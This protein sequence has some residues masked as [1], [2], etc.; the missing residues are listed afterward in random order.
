MMG[1]K[2]FHCDL[3]VYHSDKFSI[4]INGSKRLMCCPGCLAVAKFILES[5]FSDYYLYRDKPGSTIDEKFLK[6][7]FTLDLYNDNTMQKR[8]VQKDDGKTWSVT[9]AIDGITCAACTWLIERHL[10]AVKG[11]YKISVNLATCRAIITYNLEIISLSYILNEFRSIGYLA[12]PYTPKQQEVLF[13]NE[14]RRELKKLIVSAIGMLQVM[15]L[16]AALYIG[17]LRDM[18]QNYWIFI[19]WICF[20][21]TC[22]VLF[23]SARGIFYNALR[24]I[25]LKNFGMDTTVSLSLFIAFI[26]SMWN[27]I[28]KTGDIYFDSICMF[29]FFLLIGRFLEMRARHHS[30]E[31]IYGLQEL[32]V[33][34]AIIV[35]KENN[36]YNE[37]IVAIENVQVGDNILV[38]PGESIPIDGEIVEGNSSISESMITG[39]SMPI[40]KIVGDYVI[41]GTVNI[42]NDL[43][44]KAVKIKGTSTIDVMIQLLEKVSSVKPE[45][46]VLVN[47][48]AGYFVLIVIFLTMV[49]SLVWFKLGHNNVLN[50]ILSMLVVACPC[51]LSLATPVA[52]T[53]SVNALARKGFLIT[54]E[55]VLENL[56]LVTDIVFDK[57]GTLTVNNFFINKIRLNKNVTVKDVFSIAMSL[58]ENS[59]HPIARAFMSS[60]IPSYKII[61]SKNNIKNYI[62]EGVEGKLDGVVYRLGKPDFIKEWTKNYLNLNIMKEGIWIVLADK[63]NILAWFNLTNP[64]RRNLNKCINKL[65]ELNL[66]L[67]IL[68]GDSSDNVDYV[69][70][71]LGI[72][73]KNKNVSIQKKLEYIQRL[74]FNKSVVMMIGDGINDTLALSASHISVAMG[75]ATDLAKISSDSI[76]LNNNL[77]NIYKSIKH[78]RKSKQIIRQNIIWAI[79]Y[80]IFGLTLAG[81]DL[82]TPYYAAIGMSASSLIVVF[83]SLRLKKI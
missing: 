74:S 28:S 29:V 65:N 21:V 56:N 10:G 82:L 26:S 25:K 42:D 41:G 22:P 53:S 48:V 45:S 11:I 73:N 57:T 34:T 59:K 62:N 51:A 15:M 6:D 61:Y 8:F 31:I 7:S 69:A 36:L 58:E 2:C 39:E 40:Y 43:V 13:K 68:S 37:S 16:S 72:R 9:V 17:E 54:K 70:D 18:H 5:G 19:R 4:V 35:K 55:H 75:S 63:K 14:Y 49:V 79:F 32:S 33:D 3:I 83:N 78:G 23:F 38:K 81:C 67:H 20:F 52:I 27:L 60:N 47:V 71:T 30:G 12:C 46:N 66:T 50:I 76:L 24:S 80:N 44:V 77:M 1:K 64:L